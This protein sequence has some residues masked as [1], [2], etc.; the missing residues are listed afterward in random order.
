MVQKRVF[1]AFYCFWLFA[2]FRLLRACADWRNGLQTAATLALPLVDQ[3]LSGVL[4]I[5]GVL[6]GN[7]CGMKFCGELSLFRDK[8]SDVCRLQ[9][10]ILVSAVNRAAIF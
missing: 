2:L 5:G 7:F 10:I 3:R 1:F 4:L 8:P 6:F 9:S